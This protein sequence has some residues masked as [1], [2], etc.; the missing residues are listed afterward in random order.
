MTTITVADGID[1]SALRLLLAAIELGSVSK[2]A[3]RMR[4]SQPSATAKLQKLE[5][6]LGA[7]L[8]ERTPTGSVPTVEGARLAPACAEALSAVTA[9]V[10]RA[11]AV[12]SEREVLTVA[13]TRHVADHY[14]P[15]WILNASIDE[16]QVELD[17]ADTLQV[18][19]AVRAGEATIGFAEGPQAPLGLRSHVVAR[20][21]VVPVVGRSHPWHGRRA[22]VSAAELVATTLI[23]VQPGSGTRDVVESVFAEHK[24]GGVG[25]HLDVANATASR[26]SAL[27]GAGI[28]FLP[29]CWIRDLLDSADLYAVPIR[30]LTIE[31]PIRVVWR[32]VRPATQA[33][34]RLVDTAMT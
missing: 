32:G 22:T 11:E 33:A 29:E 17:E 14:L 9:L 2:A 24:W 30:G 8:L 21:R 19:R 4:V 31:Q 6:Q 7:A 23:L 12:R 20:E 5:R 26:L 18:A 10:E 25:E 27:N 16:V 13:A 28:A 34:Q 1:V 3:A 15:G